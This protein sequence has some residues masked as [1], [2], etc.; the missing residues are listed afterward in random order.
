MSDG[1]IPTL[2]GERV[3]LASEDASGRRRYVHEDGRAIAPDRAGDIVF[4]RAF[5]STSTEGDPPPRWWAAVKADT[6]IGELLFDESPEDEAADAEVA[7]WLMAVGQSHRPQSAVHLDAG[8]FHSSL[9]AWLGET[10]APT[11]S[12]SWDYSFWKAELFAIDLDDDTIP[13]GARVFEAKVWLGE[14]SRPDSIRYFISGDREA[15]AGSEGASDVSGSGWLTAPPDLLRLSGGTDA[16]PD[17]DA[18]AIDVDA[19]FKER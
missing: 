10:D 2:D 6:E 1:L 17:Q 13:K 12:A 9:Q 8:F 7:S 18:T 14:D 15:T 5:A 16:R 4:T 19:L 3:L 11:T